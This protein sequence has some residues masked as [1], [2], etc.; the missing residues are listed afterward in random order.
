MRDDAHTQYGSARLMPDD[1]QHY[2]QHVCISLS[3]LQWCYTVCC[4][5]G[6]HALDRTYI[7]LCKTPYRAQQCF[8]VIITLFLLCYFA[9]EITK[10]VGKK[11]SKVTSKQNILKF[12]YKSYEY[13]FWKK[14]TQEKVLIFCPFL[15]V[16]HGLHDIYMRKE[17][18]MWG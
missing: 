8:V 15:L 2:I 18:G 14:E 6:A 1:M 4:N 7:D 12:W 17:L 10:T 9:I 16:I 11:R 5:G 13:T 3:V